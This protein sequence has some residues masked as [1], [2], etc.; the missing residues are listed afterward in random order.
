M[1]DAL[2]AGPGG[3]IQVEQ[4]AVDSSANAVSEPRN[5]ERLLSTSA[6]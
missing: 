5:G 3:A 2:V 1:F 6:S 4:R